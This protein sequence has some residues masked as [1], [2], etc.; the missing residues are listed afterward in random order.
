MLEEQELLE[1]LKHL[2]T[3]NQ[4]RWDNGDHLE[5]KGYDMN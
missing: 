4:Q 5:V 3:T 2:Q 1:Q